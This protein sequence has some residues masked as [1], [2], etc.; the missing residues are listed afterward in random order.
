MGPW[1]YTSVYYIPW[2]IR[3]LWLVDSFSKRYTKHLTN[4]R[5]QGPYCKLMH[6]VFTTSIRGPRASH[7]GHKL[8]WKQLTVRPSNTVNKKHIFL[9]MPYFSFIYLFFI[10]HHRHIMRWLFLILSFLNLYRM[11]T[12]AYHRIFELG[13]W[14]ATVYG[15]R[16][17]AGGEGKPFFYFNISEEKSCHCSAG[18]WE[19]LK[20][21]WIMANLFY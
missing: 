9:Y 6:L 8:K 12:K 18:F 10:C 21:E 17:V 3:G 16:W 14:G 13:S 11:E 19:P 1:I 2:V 5:F 7:L 15:L 4:F 20:T